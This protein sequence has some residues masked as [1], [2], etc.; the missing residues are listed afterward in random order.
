MMAFGQSL[1]GRLRWFAPTKFTFR[2]NHSPVNKQDC[3]PTDARQRRLPLPRGISLIEL[4][5]VMGA[6]VVLI[7]A[8]ISVL[9]TVGHADRQFARRMNDSLAVNAMLDRLR[10]DVHAASA[11]RWDATSKT[12]HLPSAGGAATTYRRIVDRWERRTIT[13]EDIADAKGDLTAAFRLPAD[14]A[15]AVEPADAAAGELVH[16]TLRLTPKEPRP[17]RQ[18]PL[19]AEMVVAVGRDARLLHE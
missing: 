9:V 1:G 14:V 12:L 11:L 17:D 16:V 19:A 8:A 5:A 10:A 3:L 13:S 2:K 15:V 18:P 7:A 4:L 6:N